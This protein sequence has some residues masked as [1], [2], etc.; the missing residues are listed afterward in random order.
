VQPTHTNL[1]QRVDVDGA[2]AL[3]LNRPPVP[4]HLVEKARVERSNLLRLLEVL[5]QHLL[6]LL[7]LPPRRHCLVLVGRGE[8]TSQRAGSAGES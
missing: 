3:Y 5:V 8:Q 1:Q 2:H 6:Q 4:V 7:L